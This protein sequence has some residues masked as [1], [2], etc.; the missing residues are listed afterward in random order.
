MKT[1]I[2][3]TPPE[4][5]R[6]PKVGEVWAVNDRKSVYIRIDDELGRRALSINGLKDVFFSVDLSDGF[7][8]YCAFDRL[9]VVILEPVGGVMKFQ[10]KG[11]TQ[12]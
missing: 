6:I 2:V 4:Q 8:Y 5:K 12:E 7:V 3:K 10:P 11:D 1:E 9:G